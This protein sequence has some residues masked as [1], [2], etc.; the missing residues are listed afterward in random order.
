MLRYIQGGFR[1]IYPAILIYL[2]IYRVVSGSYIQLF[3]YTWI[4]TGWFQAHI[5][6]SSNILGYIH[7]GFRLIYP[8]L[9]IYL[10][11]YRV[12]SGSYIQLFLYLDIYR[13]DLGSYIQLFLYT[14]IYIQG[15]FRFLYT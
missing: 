13:V 10:D 5:S 12:V 11:I 15:G 1:L 4:Y 6:S 7:G 3:L 8:A 9:P 14:W 2:D